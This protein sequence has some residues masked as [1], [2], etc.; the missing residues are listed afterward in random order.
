MRGH[1]AGMADEA[2]QVASDQKLYL[3]F[4]HIIHNDDDLLITE[5]QARGWIVVRDE[6]YIGSRAVYLNQPI[7][8]RDDRSE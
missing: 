5:L 4:S 3:L 2:I 1:I 6:R 7:S 8:D